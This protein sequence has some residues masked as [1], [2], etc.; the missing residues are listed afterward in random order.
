[1][2]EKSKSLWLYGTI[3][4]TVAFV[5][6][7]LAAITQIGLNRQTQQY[8]TELQ[9]DGAAF[10][11]FN[12]NAVTVSEENQVLRDKIASLE[13]EKETLTAENK[14][15]TTDKEVGLQK[16]YAY[17]QIIA[18]RSL[19]DEGRWVEGADQLLDINPELLDP[20]GQAFYEEFGDSLIQK[21]VESSYTEGHNAFKAED[22]PLAIG[23]FEQAFK[24]DVDGR[25]AD[26]ALYFTG[27]CYMRME[28]PESAKATFNQLINDF[29]DSGYG[30]DAKRNL[31][32][33]ETAEE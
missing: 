10:G 27:L 3:L 17:E 14:A 13:K 2:K 12:R 9:Q 11:S 23:K 21:A 16:A 15:L 30:A 25:T 6:V 19:Y 18:A 22:Y 24:F 32:Q 20:S 7:A 26:D 28:A 33:L 1:M 29:P 5:L 31:A 8:A 4:F